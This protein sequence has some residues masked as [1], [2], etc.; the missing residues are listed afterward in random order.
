MDGDAVV[1]ELNILVAGGCLEDTGIA[2]PPG[3]V[4]I[5]DVFA[6]PEQGDAVK[7][8]KL[9]VGASTSKE[10]FATKWQHTMEA[11]AH[12]AS[13]PRAEAPVSRSIIAS[14]KRLYDL[15]EDAEGQWE[16]PAKRL[17]VAALPQPQLT[18]S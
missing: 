3:D 17:A 14:A 7:R 10:T 11:I 16:A 18:I 1:E 6:V 2:E 12:L 15:V 9:I 4:E 13:C 5:A 8:R